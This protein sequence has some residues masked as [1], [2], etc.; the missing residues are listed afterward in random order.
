MKTKLFL[1][2]NKK[3]KK[4]GFTWFAIF[5]TS[6]ILILS[7]VYIGWSNNE[8]KRI[9][10]INKEYKVY[11]NQLHKIKNLNKDMRRQILP[12][13]KKNNLSI[14]ETNIALV[15]FYDLYKKEFNFSL[16]KYNYG[17]KDKRTLDIN[18]RINVHNKKKLSSFFKLILSKRLIM[19]K[20]LYSD[21]NIVFGTF[22]LSI[23]CKDK[24][25]KK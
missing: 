19:V 16:S 14:Y 10:N 15:T 18:F 25:D 24:K 22:S 23:L 12:I 9:D 3:I 11:L 20:Q 4:I 5:F 2:H 13:F 21:Q 8:I 1:E 6:I 17:N 7:Y